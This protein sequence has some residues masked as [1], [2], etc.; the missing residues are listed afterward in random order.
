MLK[1]KDIK[2]YTLE[3]LEKILAGMNEPSYRA[4]QIFYW[5][6][7]KDAKSFAEMGNLPKPLIQKL[8]DSYCV[9]ALRMSKRLI[10][11]DKTEKFL[12][13]LQDANY[14]ETVFIYAKKRVTICLSTQVGCKFACSFCASG[15]MGFIR[16]LTSSEIVDQILYLRRDLKHNITNYVFMGMGEPLDNYDNTSKAILIMNDK[17]GLDIGARRITVS[18]CG[19]I[20][21]IDRLK[22]LN[23]QIDLSLSLHAVDNRLRSELM[24]INKQYPLEELIKSC[25]R[26]FKKTGRVITL[27]YVL[28]K[29]K[30]HSPRDASRLAYIAG[31][32]KSKVNLII[33]SEIAGFDHKPPEEKEIISFM[34]RLK[35]SGINVTLR[36]SK[37][38]DIQAACGQLAGRRRW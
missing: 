28:I 3:E 15:R 32:L 11:D 38:E 5:L 4:K 35:K 17:N 20:P 33:Y 36:R 34:H 13:K 18:T 10:S 37:G 23:L 1:K 16:D 7:K 21:A 8:D 9:G 26:Y 25:Q 31:K 22:E 30:N 24:P 29:G 19:I 14:I 2:N 12:F 6:Y 27:E